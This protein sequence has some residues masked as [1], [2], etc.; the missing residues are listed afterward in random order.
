M[1]YFLVIIIVHL[2]MVYNKY[3]L[4]KIKWYVY[5]IGPELKM[6]DWNDGLGPIMDIYLNPEKNGHTTFL[7][8]I[9]RV[10]Q[11][12]LRF[13]WLIGNKIHMRFNKRRDLL[14][15]S[16]PTNSGPYLRLRISS[17]KPITFLNFL[18]T[19]LFLS[20]TAVFIRFQAQMKD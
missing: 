17:D 14:L 4:I 12:R 16:C 8:L 9:F 1:F 6:F 13:I 3:F 19:S 2:L 10:I 11:I 7:L 18:K 20:L 5:L 15:F